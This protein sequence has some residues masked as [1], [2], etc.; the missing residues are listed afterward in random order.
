MRCP[1]YK[2]RSKERKVDSC[3]LTC[4]KF[5]EWVRYYINNEQLSTFQAPLKEEIIK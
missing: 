5:L 1:C 2:C 3:V 4:S